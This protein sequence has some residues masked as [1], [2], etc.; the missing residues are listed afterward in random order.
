MK[1]VA[2]SDFHTDAVT[3]GVPRFGEVARAARASVQAAVDLRR[4]GEKV[5]YVF[6]GDLCDPDVVP[7]VLRATMLIFELIEILSGEGVES[8]WLA[9][10]HDVIE[11]GS[12]LTTLSALRRFRPEIGCARAHVIEK[13]GLYEFVD[14]SNLVA[15]PYTASSCPYDPAKVVREILEEGCR[16]VVVS[17]LGVPGVQPG[18][19]SGEMARGREVLLPLAEVRNADLIIQAHY[20]RSQVFRPPGGGC[21]VHVI[22]SLARLTHGEEGHRPGYLVVDLP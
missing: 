10:N 11:D 2:A 19:E 14:G 13:P 4:G 7:D 15:L 5:A 18:E 1:V 9:G 6:A 16:N 12:G 17:H 22:G 3:A 8:F 21:P 20:H